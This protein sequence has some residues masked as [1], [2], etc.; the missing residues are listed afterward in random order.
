MTTRTVVK[1]LAGEEDLLLG[2]GSANQ[3]RNGQPVSVNKINADTFSFYK[4]GVSTVSRS[5]ADRLEDTISAKDFGAVGDGSSDD[6]AYLQAA[7]DHIKTIGGGTVYFPDGTYIVNGTLLFDPDANIPIHI[8]GSGAVTLEQQS[9]STTIRLKRVYSGLGYGNISKSSMSGLVISHVDGSSTKFAIELWQ[10]K[11]FQ[12][13][14]MRTEKYQQGLWING[15]QAVLASDFKMSVTDSTSSVVAGGAQLKITSLAD[16]NGDLIVS[17]THQISNFNLTGYKSSGVPGVYSNIRMTSSDGNHFSN[18]FIGGASQ[19]NV[20]VGADP[21]G[22]TVGAASFSSGYID[23]NGHASFGVYV[24]DGSVE[25]VGNLCLDNIFNNAPTAWGIY[26]DE[27]LKDLMVTDTIFNRPTTGAITTFGDS[28]TDRNVT[29]SSVRVKGGLQDAGDSAF[30][31]RGLKIANIFGC[32]MDNADSGAYLIE[33]P[34]GKEVNRL[35]ISNCQSV[36]SEYANLAGTVNRLD[37]EMYYNF[38]PTLNIGGD[39]TGL[40]YSANV[41][42]RAAHMNNM[43]S[44]SIYLGMTSIGSLTGDVTIEGLPVTNDAFAEACSIRVVNGAAGL[45]DE[46]MVAVV[47]SSGTSINLYANDAKLQETDIANNTIFIVSGIYFVR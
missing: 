43:V 1:A 31:L 37:G 21:S 25:S 38:T 36:G 12:F 17:W 14:N 46:H 7:F 26:A 4:S 13:H 20:W 5:I 10:C 22:G 15:G 29:I 8:R 42:G 3:T 19:A 41:R 35:A 33:V 23:S 16:K 6:T 24:D 45:Q 11:E 28:Y 2:T 27:S 47:S 9:D 18:F 44:F 32:H 39:D 40:T 34:S 30:K